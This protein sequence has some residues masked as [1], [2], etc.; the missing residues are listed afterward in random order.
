MK[1]YFFENRI[2]TF[3]TQ[4][5]NGYKVST[6]FDDR[7]TAY[8]PLTDE[9]NAF[10]LANPTASIFEINRC[11]LNPIVEPIVPTIDP[12]EQREQAY[13]TEPIIMWDGKLRTCDFCRALIVTYQLLQD[14]REAELRGLWLQGRNEIQNKYPENQ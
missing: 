2:W 3:E 7:F 10:Y 9:Q 6:T 1:N 13:A 5:G 8:I 14:T 12:R 4:L 11:E